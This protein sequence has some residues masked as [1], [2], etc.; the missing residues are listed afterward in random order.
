MHLHPDFTT[1]TQV[2]CNGPDKAPP[3]K[4]HGWAMYWD[5]MAY[6][7]YPGA[8]ASDTAHQVRQR[9]IPSEYRPFQLSF[10]DHL[11]RFLATFRSAL[12]AFSRALFRA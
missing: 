2:T 7:H 1:G 12:S 3:C 10:S 5:S 6:A 9:A 8:N 11:S 4:L